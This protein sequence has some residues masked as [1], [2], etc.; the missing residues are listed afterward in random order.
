[1][2]GGGEDVATEIDATRK[3]PSDVCT[4]I[5]PAVPIQRAVVKVEM[6]AASEMTPS[7][8][9]AS[10][11]PIS[12]TCASTGCAATASGT[13]APSVPHCPDVLPRAPRLLPT[14]HTSHALAATC[15]T[16]T[17]PTTASSFHAWPPIHS[18]AF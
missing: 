12:P 14:S 2:N 6:V 8:A 16:T 1:M 7:R 17:D 4:S 9:K 13:T 11:A 5:S 15:S 10:T 18:G 3:Q